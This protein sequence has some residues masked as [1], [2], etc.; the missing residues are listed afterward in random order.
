M[1]KYADYFTKKCANAFGKR[2]ISIINHGSVIDG[3]IGNPQDIDLVVILSDKTYLISDMQTI[4]KI[5]SP[6]SDLLDVQIFYLEE[7]PQNADLFSQNTNGCFFA[8]HLRSSCILYGDN[9]LDLIY[10][11]SP[12]Q[13]KLSLMQ[14]IRQYSHQI[15]KDIIAG[16]EIKTQKD[17]HNLIKVLIKII[18]DI[19]M[20]NNILVKN[21]YLL[22]DKFSNKYD[23]L[24]DNKESQ[25]LFNALSGDYDISENRDDIYK[26][27]HQI[28]EKLYQ[29][30]LQIAKKELKFK[31][32]RL[33]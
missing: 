17:F 28:A 18:K 30:A 1:K 6:I 16:K 31:P 2:L 15:R 3:G 27:I 33:N 20:I 25:F 5:V 8:W 26:M 21:P 29:L 10:G 22:L 9:I 7:I 4:N 12:Y 32:I 11:P 19:L 23:N 13:L 14:K 24:L